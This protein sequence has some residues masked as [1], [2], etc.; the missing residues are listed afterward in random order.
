MARIRNKPAR[1]AFEAKVVILEDWVRGGAV[2]THVPRLRTLDDVRL[3][4]DGALGLKAWTSFSV[5]AP[6]GPNYDL[7]LRLKALLPRLGALQEGIARAPKSPSIRKTEA[8]REMEK[9]HRALVIQNEQL[10]HAIN[11]IRQQLSREMTMRKIA[12]VERDELKKKLGA[13]IPLRIA[14]SDDD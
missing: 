2:P 12:E 10:L 6:S 14:R 9:V 3:W 7:R 13:V 4:E 5:A 8:Q 1:A 11:Q